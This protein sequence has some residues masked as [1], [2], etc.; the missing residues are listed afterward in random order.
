[1]VG[2]TPPM[3]C[4]TAGDVRDAATLLEQQAAEIERLRS[5]AVQYLSL[6]DAMGYKEGPAG[7]SPEEYAEALRKDAE[8][9]RWLA[10]AC[11]SRDEPYRGGWSIHVQGAVPARH[12]CEDARDAAIDA[13]MSTQARAASAPDTRRAG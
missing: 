1:M 13:A 6:T 2:E 3:D 10:S 11:K 8:R 5:V 4:L 7:L 12:D 9:Y